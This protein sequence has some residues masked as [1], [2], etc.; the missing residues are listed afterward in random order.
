MISKLLQYHTLPPLSLFT[1]AYFVAQKR[2]SLF[3]A[4]SQDWRVEI[5]NPFPYWSL[6]TLRRATDTTYIHTGATERRIRRFVEGRGRGFGGTDV[7]WA[8]GD[9]RL[10][11]EEGCNP[12]HHISGYATFQLSL[13]VLVEAITTLPRYI[14]FKANS[15]VVL[16]EQKCG[17]RG[18]TDEQT[19]PATK[20]QLLWCQMDITLLLS[21]RCSNQSKKIKLNNK[22]IVV[23]HIF[24]LFFEWLGLKIRVDSP[25]WRKQA[26]LRT[27]CHIHEPHELLSALP[28]SFRKQNTRRCLDWTCSSVVHHDKD[29]QFTEEL[30]LL[31]ILWKAISPRRPRY[32]VSRD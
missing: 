14:L 29:P 1:S 22:D 7:Q 5:H 9:E 32:P 16:L 17:D 15:P 26:F 4:I 28:K 10:R 11:E 23:T 12:T 6:R 25:P 19:L 24:P 20:L 13:V 21:T 30:W 31:L 3:T 8:S 27:L 2:Q 18:G